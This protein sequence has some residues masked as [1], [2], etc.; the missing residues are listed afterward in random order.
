MD[1]NEERTK[2]F[3]KT[4]RDLIQQT[5]IT[6]IEKIEKFNGE[7]A[8]H[9][10]YG[11]TEDGSEKIIFYPLAGSEKQLTTVDAD[12]ILPESKMI[13]MWQSECPSCQLV[14]ATP[15]LLDNELLWELV[16]Y[17]EE[18]HYVFDYRSIYDGSHYEDIRYLRQFN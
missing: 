9:V 7:Q 10:V 3:S 12:E 2:G 15:A 5:S 4:Q 13:G 16:Y 1:L 14:K 6:D 18:N 11:K 17:D 8:Y